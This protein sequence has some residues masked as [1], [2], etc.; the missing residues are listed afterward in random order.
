MYPGDL[1]Y[2]RDH[3]WAR[4]ERDRAAIGITPLPSRQGS[5]VRRHKGSDT[6]L[7]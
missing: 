1:K 3:E 5:A 2:A 6:A 7:Q 4:P